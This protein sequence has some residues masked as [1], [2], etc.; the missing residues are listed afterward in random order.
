M[1][2]K[3]EFES[4]KNDSLCFKWGTTTIL[5]PKIK[6]QHDQRWQCAMSFSSYVEHSH[7]LP[8]QMPYLLLCFTKVQMLNK[9]TQFPIY[10][11]FGFVFLSSLLPLF[12]PLLLCM[13]WLSFP[14]AA[15]LLAFFSL[16]T[17]KHDLRLNQL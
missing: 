16:T 8:P 2:K 5:W 9:N 6:L 17:T 14:F 12:L 3:G 15:I 13:S 4:L 11:T 7:N 10:S 1:K